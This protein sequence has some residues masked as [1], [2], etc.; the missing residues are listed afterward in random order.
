M[1]AASHAVPPQHVPYMTPAQAQAPYNPN[2]AFQPAPSAGFAAADNRYVCL[3]IPGLIM[4]I[5]C[6]GLEGHQ[7]RV[8]TPGYIPKNYQILLGKLVNPP[9]KLI[10]Y[11]RSN[12]SFSCH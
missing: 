5:C 7:W 8:Q 1:Y 6:K 12:F 10:P 11:F 3:K 4:E 9:I 2:F